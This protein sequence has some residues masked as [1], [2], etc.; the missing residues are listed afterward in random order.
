NSFRWTLDN[1]I[2]ISTGLVGGQIQRTGRPNDKPVTVRKQNIKLDPRTGDF[3]LTS[4][5]GQ[6]GLTI[7][8]WGDVF[9]CDNS[10]PILHLIYDSAYLARNPYVEAP[11][12]MVDVNAAGKH[13]GLHKISPPEPWRVART[14]MRKNKQFDG[15]DEGGK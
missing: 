5:G 9:V 6:H 12:P 7:D 14:E 4:G 11:S 10:N 13:A 15:S 3:T 8:D 2:L 1:R